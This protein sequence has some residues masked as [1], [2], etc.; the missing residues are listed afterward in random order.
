MQQ[1]GVEALHRDT[2]VGEPGLQCAVEGDLRR[3]I[4]PVPE[5]G[6][7]GGLLDK[8]G[9]DVT[10][11]PPPQHERPSQSG[12]LRAQRRQRA[13]EPPARGAAERPD[14]RAFLVQHIGDDQRPAGRARRRDGR[15]VGKAQ[16]VAQPDEGRV[17]GKAWA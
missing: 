5:H 6:I 11:R 13:P 16:V 2:P 8:R 9:N 14:A 12:D 7:G 1:R 10:G 3:A 17:L 4:A 15:I